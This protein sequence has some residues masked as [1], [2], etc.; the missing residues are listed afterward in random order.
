MFRMSSDSGHIFR[1]TAGAVFF[2]YQPGLGRVLRVVRATTSLATDAAGTRTG[3]T[4]SPV[5]WMTCST[6]RDTASARQR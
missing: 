3:S 2:F 4:G 1:A 6:C 5:V